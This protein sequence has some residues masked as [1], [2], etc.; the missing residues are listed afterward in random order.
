MR[1]GD[2]R[3]RIQDIL[4]TSFQFDADTNKFNIRTVL[5]IRNTQR[6]EEQV[7]ISMI[8]RQVTESLPQAGN[9]QTTNIRQYA[10]KAKRDGL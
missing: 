9:D 8:R 10:C 3:L 5:A 1:C 2:L 4:E 6:Q 7:T